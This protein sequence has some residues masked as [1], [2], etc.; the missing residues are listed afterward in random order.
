MADVTWLTDHQG[1]PGPLPFPP[2]NVT[3]D[4]DEES[5]TVAG[6]AIDSCDSLNQSTETVVMRD[7]AA[8]ARKAAAAARRKSVYYNATPEPTTATS[9]S[10]DADLVALPRIKQHRHHHQ[11]HHHS[12]RADPEV[13]KMTSLDRGRHAS[14]TDYVGGSTRRR[15]QAVSAEAGVAGPEITSSKPDVGSPPP[16][17]ND[18]A[19]RVTRSTV[20]SDSRVVAAA[21]ADSTATVRFRSSD[22]LRPGHQP[23]AGAD[24]REG[25]AD[26]ADVRTDGDAADGGR[27]VRQVPAGRVT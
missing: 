26:D 10:S 3:F 20:H 2:L 25:D 11:R 19:C 5:D 14:R 7:A 12:H 23:H 21:A 24:W 16:A 4:V 27:R 15:K 6:G 18:A 1:K 13:E 17:R 8:A 9:A 22:T